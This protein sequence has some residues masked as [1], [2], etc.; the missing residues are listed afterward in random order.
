M[1]NQ[2]QKV[3]FRE[4]FSS[5]RQFVIP[6]F[7]RGYAWG[8]ENWKT[9]F[10]DIK[11]EILDELSVNNDYKDFEHFFS[12]VVVMPKV[13]N[14]LDGIERFDILDGQQRITTVYIFIA[15][16]KDLLLNKT[17]DISAT[18]F[19]NS[20]NKYLENKLNFGEEDD[21]KK[22]KVYSNKGDRLQ[23]YKTVFK[24]EPNSPF[25]FFDNQFT[26]SDSRVKKYSHW[27][28]SGNKSYRIDHWSTEELIVL[29]NVILDCLKIVWIPLEQHS[30]NAQSIFESLNAK[31]TQLEPYELLCNY[32]FR[33]FE[34]IDDKETEKYYNDYWI[35]TENKIGTKDFDDYIMHLYSIGESKNIG[36]G[37]KIYTHFKKYNK[38]ISYEHSIEHL[39]N[40]KDMAVYYQL[41]INP[42]ATNGID[43]KIILLLKNIKTTSMASATPFLMKLLKEHLSNKISLDDTVNILQEIL[44]MIIRVKIV[45]HSTAKIS[46]FFPNLYDYIEHKSDKI[47][48]LHTKFKEYDFLIEDNYF[49]ERFIKRAIYAS[50][51]TSFVKML[52]VEIDKSQHKFNQFPDYDT[53]NTIEHICPQNGRDKTGWTDYLGEDSKNENLS[54]IIH[55]IGNLLLLSHPANSSASNNPFDDKVAKYHKLTYLNEDI[56]GRFNNN[57]KWNINA[58]KDRSETLVNIALN[59]WKWK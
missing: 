35:Y 29:V 40:L 41:V 6:F 16:V 57:I 47:N 43:G 15:T 31:G 50:S 10:N 53:L 9:L 18:N 46:E 59:I 42:K 58:I 36:K 11:E 49:K 52:L 27:L 2:V 54:S 22:L 38:S 55:S 21:Y 26:N 32:I 39:K 13:N 14:S 56:I 3:T 5:N 12:S 4:L 17:D 34:Q 1:S 24:S 7:Q 51:N 44:T 8:V 28:T 37:R 45:G 33:G 48:A 25:L 20:L 30:N 19:A 23:T